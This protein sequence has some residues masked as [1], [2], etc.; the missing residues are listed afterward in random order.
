VGS[1]PWWWALPYSEFWEGVRGRAGEVWVSAVT[2]GVV[3]GGDRL[4][5]ERRSVRRVKRV[6]GLIDVGGHRLDSRGQVSLS[7]G[8]PIGNLRR[9][10]RD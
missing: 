9:V 2:G 4:I 6:I 5:G 7:D 3:T 1:D 10:R 8:V